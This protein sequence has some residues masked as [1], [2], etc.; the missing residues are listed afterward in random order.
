MTSPVT[1]T[2]QTHNTHTHNTQTHKNA[3]AFDLVLPVGETWILAEDLE[4]Q[5]LSGSSLLDSTGE[6]LLYL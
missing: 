3:K 4:Y 5:S 2:K 6:S 1:E